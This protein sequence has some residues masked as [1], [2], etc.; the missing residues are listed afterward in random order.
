M[1][2]IETRTRESLDWTPIATATPSEP[3]F[4]DPQEILPE[5]DELRVLAILSRARYV[6]MSKIHLPCLRSRSETWGYRRRIFDKLSTLENKISHDQESL[7]ELHILNGHAMFSGPRRDKKM[8][9]I[10]EVIDM[11][12]KKDRE[13]NW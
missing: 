1:V 11:S 6:N 3:I 12:V 13:E 2:K 9:T 5:N 7:K 8:Y 4:Y 10:D